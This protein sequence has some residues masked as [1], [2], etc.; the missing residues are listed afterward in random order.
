MSMTVYWSDC[1]EI[2][3][4]GLFDEWGKEQSAF[5]R[6]CIVVRDMT[7][8]DWLKSYYL[9]N[10]KRRQVLMNLDFV[11]LEEFVNNWLF[12][13][14]HDEPLNTRNPQ[15]HPYAK[16][17]L[18][19]RIYCILAD[20]EKLTEELEPLKKYVGD[21]P[22]NAPRRR[23]E[24]AT[25]LAKLFDDYLNSRFVMLYKW[26]NGD[27]TELDGVPSWQRLLYQMLVQ[28]NSQTYASNYAQL[29]LE[30]SARDAIANGFPKYRAIHIFDVPDMPEPTFFLLEKMAKEMDITFWSFNPCGDWL[31]DTPTQKEAIRK[32]VSSTRNALKNGKNPPEIELTSVFDTPRERLLGTLATGARA[33][34]GAQVD[35]DWVSPESVLGEKGAA[36]EQLNRANISVHSCYSPRRELEAVREG[37]HDFFTKHPDAKP[38]EALVLCADWENYAPIIEAVFNNSASHDGFIPISVVGGVAGDTPISRSFND[39]LAFRENRFEV[40]AVFALLGVP[41]IRTRFGLDENGVD[42]LQDMVKKA[43]IHWGLDDDDVKATVGMT[44]G[45]SHYPFTWRRGLDRLALDM[46]YGEHD[47]EGVVNAEALGELLPTGSVEGDR[48]QVL[49]RLNGFIEALAKLRTQ[50]AV[51]CACT[52]DEWQKRLLEVV[53]TFYEDSDEYIPELKR[54]RTAIQK[55]CESAVD[56]KMTDAIPSD[57]IV[58]AVTSNIRNIIP[59]SS[60]AADAVLFAPLKSAAATPHRF[61]WICGLNDGAFP[62]L[63]NRPSID[64]IGKHP[65]PFDVSPRDRDGLALLKAVLSVRAGCG[66]DSSSSPIGVTTAPSP[67]SSPNSSDHSTAQSAQGQ[68]MGTGVYGE[69]AL[70]YVG[71]DIRTNEKIPSSVLLNELVEYLEKEGKRPVRF[72]HP[73]QAYSIRYFSASGELPPSYS[74]ADYRVA[75]A[76]SQKASTA[77]T[78]DARPFCAFEL[79]PNGETVIPADDLVEFFARPNNFLIKKRLNLSTTWIKGFDDE[80]MQTVAL[81]KRQKTRLILDEELADEEKKALAKVFVEWGNAPDASTAEKEIKEFCEDENTTGLRTYPLHFQNEKKLKKDKKVLAKA[82]DSCDETIVEAYKEFCMKAKTIGYSVELAIDG[83]KLCIPFNYM[84]IALETKAGLK[85]HTFYMEDAL[86]IY[87]SS[88]VAAWIRHIIGHAAG[89]SFATVVFCQKNI[90]AK[91]FKPMKQDEAKTFLEKYI[92]LALKPLPS[93]LPNY[94]KTSPEDDTLLGTLFECVL[95]DA[96]AYYVSTHK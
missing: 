88:L 30:T 29:L 65:S 89:Y 66:D 22:K 8:R 28:E 62:H 6:T 94:E 27:N 23:F 81:D 75:S 95:H 67:S 36:F 86:E 48:A 37:L 85:D 42:R 73:L 87:E 63:E 15:S 74:A 68:C 10:L 34:L 83:K 24:L 17:V 33:V 55:V 14:T 70:S 47:N 51:G 80:D 84:A 11:P 93:E 9:L 78:G 13:K 3:A 43:N 60:T 40:S 90:A 57:V 64:V 72:D 54:I 4:K 18:T 35:C 92:C 12:A 52:V 59:G 50:F 46:L 79:N 56:A 69:L 1:L 7:T 2:L 26:E 96:K 41:A 61:I 16:P 32:L 45:K 39:L 58:P 77:C 44:N 5:E 53:G 25:Q 82:E 49:M 20:E 38:H 76:L 21:D 31:A 71:K 19:W 91:T